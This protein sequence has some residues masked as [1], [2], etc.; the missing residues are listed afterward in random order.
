[1]VSFL[2]GGREGIYLGVSLH[3]APLESIGLSHISRHDPSWQGMARGRSALARGVKR[4]ENMGR[5]NHVATVFLF[6]LFVSAY[7]VLIP[8]CHGVVASGLGEGNGRGAGHRRP[9]A[10]P[11]SSAPLPTQP[12]SPHSRSLSYDR[13]ER[14]KCTKTPRKAKQNKKEKS[15]QDHHQPPSHPHPTHA[16]LRKTASGPKR[17]RLFIGIFRTVHLGTHTQRQN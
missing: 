16:H 15:Q 9:D 17:K 6:S 13:N 8:Y 14:Q 7:H 12:R 10:P 1:M 5:K 11:T 4:F 3:S 2:G